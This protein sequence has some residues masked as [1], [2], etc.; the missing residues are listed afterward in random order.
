[1]A[2]RK[3]KKAKVGVKAST[4]RQVRRASKD[5]AKYKQRNAKERAKRERDIARGEKALSRL[6]QS[7]ITPK[8]KGRKSSAKLTQLTPEFIFN[9]YSN[10]TPQSIKAS[11]GGTPEEQTRAMKLEYSRLRAVAQKR[12][13]RLSKSEYEGSEIFKYYNNQFKKLKDIS[14]DKLPEAL[15]SVN[16]FLQNPLST[17]KGQTDLRNERINTLREYGYDVNVKN[18]QMVVDVLEAVRMMIND[19]FYDSDQVL[20]DTVDIINNMLA[21]PNVDWQ[22]KSRYNIANEVYEKYANS[23]YALLRLSYKKYKGED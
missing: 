1:M 16:R 4:I 6:V 2:R 18:F 23:S 21:N 3:K 9:G 11:F 20:Q 13:N 22:N 17:I 5:L 19:K 10:Y 7:H 8:A 14:P 12:L 15:V